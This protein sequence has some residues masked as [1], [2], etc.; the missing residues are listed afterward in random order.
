MGLEVGVCLPHVS[1]RQRIRRERKTTG[2]VPNGQEMEA[3]HPKSRPR[4]E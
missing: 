3:V 1:E 4:A 2:K